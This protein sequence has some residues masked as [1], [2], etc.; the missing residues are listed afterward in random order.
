MAEHLIECLIFKTVA[1]WLVLNSCPLVYLWVINVVTPWTTVT[2]TEITEG[3]QCSFIK[4]YK[5]SFRREMMESKNGVKK[6]PGTRNGVCSEECE[7]GE[8]AGGLVFIFY[9]PPPPP[10]P[11]PYNFAPQTILSSFKKEGRCCFVEEQKFFLLTSL[12]F[13]QLEKYKILANIWGAKFIIGFI[14]YSSKF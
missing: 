3:G 5:I 4:F 12:W 1:I 9:C 6:C 2:R 7:P 10:P 13:L 8:L 11:P 14:Y